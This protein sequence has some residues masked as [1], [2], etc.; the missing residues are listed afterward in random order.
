VEATKN[1]TGEITRPEGTPRAG[2]PGITRH[3]FT[4]SLFHF[5][6][7]AAVVSLPTI[8]PLLYDQRYIISRYSYI[9]TLFLAGLCVTILIQ[10][11]IGTYAR[12]GYFRKILPS[13]IMGL[14]ISLLLLTRTERFLTFLLMFLLFRT[15]TSF[16][17]PVGIAWINSLARGRRLDRAMGIQSAMGDLGVFMSF[18]TGGFLAERMGWRAPLLTW[19]LIAVM[20][21][22]SGFVLS[23]RTRAPASREAGTTASKGF[24]WRE[25]FGSIKPLVPA[26][27]L[28]GISWAIVIG[29]APSLFHH[30]MAVSLSHTGYFLAAWIGA[31]TISSLLYGKIVPHMGH[32]VLLLLSYTVVLVSAI[33]LSLTQNTTLAVATMVL[34]GFFIFLTYPCLLSCVGKNIQDSSGPSAFSIVANLQIMGGAVFSFLAGFLSDSFGITSPFWILAAVALVVI[35]YLFVRGKSLLPDGAQASP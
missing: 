21:S 13:A 15:A 27:I 3:I 26:F 20:V 11:L 31:G 25:S 22:V 6:N 18:I 9:G 19:A 1:A 32:R 28:G 8:Y 35:V 34:F 10:F 30:R 16:Y 14:G 12:E 23:S 4:I 5:V 33:T 7:D 2:G 24:S 29:Y 17:H